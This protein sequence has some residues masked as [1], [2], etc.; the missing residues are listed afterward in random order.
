MKSGNKDALKS[1]RGRYT[2]KNYITTW[3]F[4]L[5]PFFFNFINGLFLKYL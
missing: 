3:I 5:I 4:T 1:G 2:A